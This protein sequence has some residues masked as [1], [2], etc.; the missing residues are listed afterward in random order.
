MYTVKQ[1]SS[2]AGVSA[3]TLHYY[4]EIGLLKPTAVEEN[5]YRRYGEQAV[6][7]LQQILFYKEMGFS[8]EKI[9]EMVN[10]PDFN[11]L[12]A[13]EQHKSALHSRQEHLSRLIDTVDQTIS[14]LRGKTKMSE[15][16][17]F[18]VF[19]EDQQK[20]YEKEA[21][22]RWPDT[23]A[24]SARRWKSYTDADK[25]HIGEEGEAVYRDL[26]KVMDQ[27]PGSEVVQKIVAR[28]HQHL[29]YFYEP[30]VELLR[31]LGHMY[32]DD[33]RFA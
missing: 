28:W 21:A 8:L 9:H 17:L 2:L 11:L 7:L 3:R 20:E 29:R 10:R 12:R 24:E 5:G 15:K 32:N 33:P 27:D 1:L 23:Y 25:K 30:N 22:E 19:S 31:G 13:L 4:D 14:H 16:K 6:Y 26:L 18:E